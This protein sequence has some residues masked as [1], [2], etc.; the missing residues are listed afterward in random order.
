[1]IMITKKSTQIVLGIFIITTYFLFAFGPEAKAQVPKEGTISYT[2]SLCATFKALPMGE[3]RLQMTYEIFGVMIGETPEDLFHNASIR[4][5]G[6]FHAVKGEY[7]NS[8][9]FCV[10]TRLDGDQIFVTYK[11]AGKVGRAYKGTYT[12][13]GGTGKLVGIQGSIEY[14]GGAVRRA[15]EGT[16]QVYDRGKGHYKMP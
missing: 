3:E 6:G 4:C 10:A 9:G 15:A 5:L 7:N 11:M 12:I 2:E 16:F 1:M 14:T 8:S 13:V